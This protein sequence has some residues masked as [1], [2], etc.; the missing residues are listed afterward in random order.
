[1][2]RERIEKTLGKAIKR[3][4]HFYGFRSGGG[5]RVLS[6]GK[7]DKKQDFYGEHPNVGPALE[8]LCD[9]WDHGSKRPYRETYGKVYDHYL[10]GSS[11]ADSLLDAWILRGYNIRVRMN[12]DQIEAHLEGYNENIE[13]ITK[14]AQADGFLSAIDAALRAPE[15]TRHN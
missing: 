1:M 13:P 3:G 7:E 9:D 6:L 5:L 4:Y 11:E 14:T 12:G 8:I 15:V 10:T 2:N